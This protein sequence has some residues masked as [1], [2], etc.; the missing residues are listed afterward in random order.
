[1]QNNNI[2][3]RMKKIGRNQI[4][5]LRKYPRIERHKLQDAKSPL[6]THHMYKRDSHLGKS[7]RNFRIMWD[8]NLINFQ[9]IS[10]IQK[11]KN[12][13]DIRFSKRTLEGRGIKTRTEQSLYNSQGDDF[14]PRT[15]YPAKLIIKYNKG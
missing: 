4:N 10:H 1:M 9:K 5:N 7:L 14:Q 8:I 6:R 3:E 11:I 13:N 2:P 15:L 12:Q